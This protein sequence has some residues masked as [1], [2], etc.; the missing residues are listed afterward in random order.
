MIIDDIYCNWND[1]IRQLHTAKVTIRVTPKETTDTPTVVFQQ[2]WT[3][4]NKKFD[5]SENEEQPIGLYRG[6]LIRPLANFLQCTPKPLFNISE[7]RIARL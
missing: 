2:P 6:L 1:I 5:L 4:R 7:Q 3:S